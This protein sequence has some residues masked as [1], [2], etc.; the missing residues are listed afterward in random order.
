MLVCGGRDFD[1]VFSLFRVLDQAH[2][3][4]EITC[5]IHGGARGADTMANDWAAGRGV[6]VDPYWAH[7]KRDGKRAGP[8]RNQKMLDE[9]KPDLVIAFPGGR[10]TADM[11][12][13]AKKAGVLVI[14]IASALD[15]EAS[16]AEGEETSA[17]T[18]PLSPLGDES[19]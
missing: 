11:V 4:N 17:P 3:T 10:G 13:R 15:T 16:G 8:I 14:Q 1:D 12:R 5:I 2:H 9:G 18:R 6:E 7:W 19:E